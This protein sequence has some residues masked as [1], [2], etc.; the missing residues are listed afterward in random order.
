M[1][2]EELFWKRPV[3]SLYAYV[4]KNLPLYTPPPIFPTKKLV[5]AYS[6]DDLLRKLQRGVC[7][8]SF[9]FFY[10]L[11]GSYYVHSNIVN[12]KGSIQ[13]CFLNFHVSNTSLPYLFLSDLLL[14][15]LGV[16]L[17]AH[18]PSSR[19]SKN[20]CVCVFCF[21]SCL[22]SLHL[23]FVWN[24]SYYT[25]TELLAR[26]KCMWILLFTLI[27]LPN[28]FRKNI[29]YLFIVLF[30]PPP[31]RICMCKAGSCTTMHSTS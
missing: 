26:Y 15:S 18:N 1:C 8:F 14:N 24:Y 27:C 16:W 7:I 22:L 19:L 29:F 10:H 4:R 21:L 3:H 2:C 20:M 23:S 25:S 9:S 31:P 11:C 6:C 30:S 17:S 13:A 5:I 12:I 28:V